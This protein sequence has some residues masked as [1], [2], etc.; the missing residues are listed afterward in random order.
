MAL[1]VCSKLHHRKTPEICKSFQVALPG[2][3][4]SGREL[5]Q[6]SSSWFNLVWG[7]TPC[8]GGFELAQ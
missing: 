3:D 5:A 1:S 2:D 6:V 7:S 4:P 8:A